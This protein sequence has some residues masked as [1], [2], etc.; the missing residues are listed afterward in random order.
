M[1]PKYRIIRTEFQLK[2]IKTYFDETAKRWVSEV[3]GTTGDVATAKRI[4][5]E[6]EGGAK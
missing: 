2:I 3:V 1:K 6:L 5:G 4:L